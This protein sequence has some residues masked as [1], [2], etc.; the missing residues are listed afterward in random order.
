MPRN[1]V[2]GIVSG[3]FG[4]AWGALGLVLAAWA[5]TT[6]LE[7]EKGFE[8][9]HGAL[10]VSPV[11][12][13]WDPVEAASYAIN[14][15]GV[16]AV[17]ALIALALAW[18]NLRTARIAFRASNE[19][20]DGKGELQ[21]ALAQPRVGRPFEGV[22]GLRGQATP[23]DEYDLTLTAAKP[24]SSAAYRA[25]HKVRARQGAQGVNLPFRF[26]VPASAPAGGGHRW[27]LEF[28]PAGRRVV[29]PSWF[30]VDLAPAPEGEA[31]AAMIPAAGMSTGVPQ[32]APVLAHASSQVD[33]YVD[34]IDQLY[35]ALG[36]KLTG[37]QR[38]QMRAK[39]AG[40][41]GAAMRQQVEAFRKLS[42]RH[43]KLIKYALI[44]VVL[45]FFVLP[46]VLGILGAVLGAIFG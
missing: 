15:V 46:F 4:L 10:L 19:S 34:R 43:V 30:E 18:S 20:Q 22:I 11:H 9:L 1:P 7:P 40:P 27:R 12:L 23:G 31:R 3:A 28:A 5:A 36:G 2:A 37:A 38:E 25:E 42:P 29:R 45:V 35:G 44:G 41:N 39:L 13:P 26:E 33:G 21:P 24:G 16:V 6:M 14:H 8:L 32:Q 17:A